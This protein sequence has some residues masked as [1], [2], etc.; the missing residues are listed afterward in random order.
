VFIAMR[1]KIAQTAI[2]TGGFL[3]MVKRTVFSA[4]IFTILFAATAMAAPSKKGSPGWVPSV[5]AGSDPTISVTFPE[6]GSYLYWLQYKEDGGKPAVTAP[7]HVA[8]E[9]TDIEVPSAGELRIYNPKSGNLA[10]KKL[11]NLIGKKE[12]KLKEADFDRVGRVQIILKPAEGKPDQRVE[13]A[14]VTVKDSL[15]DTYT[16]VVDPTSEGVAEFRGIAGGMESVTVAYD[17]GK[18]TVEMD[19][20]LERKDIVFTHPIVI[21]SDVRTV[22]VA[23]SAAPGAP[24]SGPASRPERQRGGWIQSL[25]GIAFLALMILIGY[26]LLKSKGV[27]LENSLKKAGVQLPQDNDAAYGTVPAAPAPEPV[28]PTIC[29]FCGQRKDP[30]TGK[31]ACS[32]D[33]GA[34]TS[35][36]TGAPRLIGTQGPY[37][38]N[39]FEVTGNEM[40]IGR[41]VTNT[42]S[43]SDDTTSSR[44]HAKIDCS[45]GCYTITDLGSSNGT[46]VNGAKI[47]G[48]QALNPGDEIQIGSTK[49]RFEA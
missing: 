25:A 5:A 13:S 42:V 14:V 49:F 31:C 29:P 9:S 10:V 38:G 36:A 40:T 30:A 15:S 17:G 41:D 12:L 44:R 27:T 28:D 3:D 11:D 24:E 34:P 45:G 1:M 18:M 19:V 8:G 39:I 7:K 32:I 35:M 23:A 48:S 22:K 4:V 6:K 37:S 43:L 26:V 46:F 33:G 20:P 16:T 2:F 47:A 21:S